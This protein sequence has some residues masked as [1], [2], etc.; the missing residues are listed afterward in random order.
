MY[1]EG[2]LVELARRK[3]AVRQRIVRHREQCA[4][5][6]AVAFGPLRWLDLAL[7]LW[8]QYG[9]LA[10]MVAMPF[11][12]AAFS[13]KSSGS[14]IFRTVLRWAPSVV[15]VISAFRRAKQK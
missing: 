4:E 12:T 2:Q 8:R 3:A 1:P 14:S 7:S 5:A 15:G 10:R 9:P 6:A 13:P 11:G